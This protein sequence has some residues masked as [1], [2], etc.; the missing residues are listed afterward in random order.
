MLI[1]RILGVVRRENKVQGYYIRDEETGKTY[2]NTVE[3]LIEMSRRGISCVNAEYNP[4]ENKF[5]GVRVDLNRLPIYDMN[6]GLCSKKSLTVISVLVTGKL[7]HF[8]VMN[9]HGKVILFREDSLIR[10]ITSLRDVYLTNAKVVRRNSNLIISSLRGT[11][12]KLSIEEYNK[13][14]G[15]NK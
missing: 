14:R 1:Y 8:K 5:K 15:I 12:P 13:M 11:F 10:Y 4:I 6:T 2:V 3:E 9:E 7:K